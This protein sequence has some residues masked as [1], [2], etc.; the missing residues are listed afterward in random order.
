MAH[1]YFVFLR[2]WRTEILGQ[3]D[4]GLDQAIEPWITKP[5]PGFKT[6]VVMT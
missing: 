2:A 4:A 3:S 5:L 1:G 6:T